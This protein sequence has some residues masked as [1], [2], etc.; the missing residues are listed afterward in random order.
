[1]NNSTIFAFFFIILLNSVFSSELANAAEGKV[2]GANHSKTEDRIVSVGGSVTEIIY[3]LGGADTIVAVDSTSIYPEGASLKP[4]VG[5]MR[6][7]A[8]EPILALN[9]T[10]VLAV[11]DAGPKT[12]L[13]Q[14]ASAGLNVILIP[15]KPSLDGVFEKIS[16]VAEA[17]GKQNDGLILSN[18]IKLKIKNTQNS[19]SKITDKPRVLFLL[20]F[21]R[22]GAPQAAGKNTS[23]DSIIKLAGGIN[24]IQS[25]DGYKPLS[26]EAAVAS[27]PDVIIST[28]RSLKMLGGVEG[29]VKIPEIAQTPAGKR[30][31]VFAMDGLLLLGFG[32]R[33]DT[34]IQKLAKYL[35]PE[36]F[37]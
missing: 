13:K 31:K 12:V 26:P 18:K 10:V 20:S 29:L 14:L 17:I 16:H 6:R 19:I 3:A 15:D 9:S 7:L 30:E 21:G 24:A 28:N 33:I 22:G 23:A 36:L 35:H 11:K 1:M 27:L 2:K 37:Q 5:Y 4:N 25:F 32:P 8:A 34:A